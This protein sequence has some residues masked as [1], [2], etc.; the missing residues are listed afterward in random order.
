MADVMFDAA[1][2]LYGTT[3]RDDT[4]TFGSVLRSRHRLASANNFNSSITTP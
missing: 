1:G 4:T 3:R 2:N